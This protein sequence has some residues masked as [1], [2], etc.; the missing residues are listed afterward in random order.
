M[1]PI[2]TISTVGAVVGTLKSLTETTQTGLEVITQ[3]KAALDEGDV[4]TG[5]LRLALLEVDHNL[6]LIDA[7]QL[8][9]SGDEARAGFLK[10]AAH[11]KYDA[12]SALLVQWPEVEEPAIPTD[13]ED[14]EAM[15]AWERTL[16]DVEAG[17][18]ILANARFV[19]SRA[20]VLASLAKVPPP[21]IK[22]LR[23]NIRY[24][25]LQA[26]H[27]ELLRLLSQKEA[28]TDWLHRRASGAEPHG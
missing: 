11:L 12:L 2:A 9:A 25:N 14:E 13:Y 16:G 20:S 19:V 3:A 6:A 1:D 18:Q 26:A 22:R 5:L 4:T 21:A 8:D 7:L 27:L 15:R 23:L 28:L 24:R 10:A 17:P